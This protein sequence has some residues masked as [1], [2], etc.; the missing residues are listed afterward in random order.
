VRGLPN[1]FQVH[2][3]D[4]R[5]RDVARLLPC[6]VCWLEAAWTFRLPIVPWIETIRLEG[7]S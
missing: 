3:T 7:S 6:A 1:D 4:A 2:A 5:S